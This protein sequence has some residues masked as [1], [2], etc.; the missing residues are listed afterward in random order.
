MVVCMLVCVWVYSSFA[1]K[2]TFTKST[3]RFSNMNFFVSSLLSFEFDCLLARL[4]CWCRRSALVHNN[5]WYCFCIFV[6]VPALLCC[7]IG[8]A[9]DGES[10]RERQRER[11]GDAFFY[12][13]VPVYSVAALS[14]LYPFVFFFG[15]C[16]LKNQK[17]NWTKIHDIQEM[18]S[19]TLACI[20]S[21]LLSMHVLMCVSAIFA[22]LHHM[23][24]S[25]PPSP[26]LLPIKCFHFHAYF[27]W[28][29]SPN[30]LGQTFVRQRFCWLFHPKNTLTHSS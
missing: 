28:I 9:R 8:I 6:L 25:S 29:P 21:I 30:F 22:F 27:N 1:R 23:H 5:P 11:T 16:W 18:E 3:I 2:H 4:Q 20:S 17:K 19:Y 15:F 10:E 12:T 24:P 14:I 13:L 7:S 26:S